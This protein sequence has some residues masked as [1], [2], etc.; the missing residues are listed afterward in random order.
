MVN[1]RSAVV[2]CATALL[3][4]SGIAHAERITLRNGMVLEVQVI[5]ANDTSITMKK[6]DGTT[7]RLART[8]I[9]SIE[10]S[11]AGFL[12]LHR[13][14]DAL[15]KGDLKAARVLLQAALEAGGDPERVNAA[16][17]D[18]SNREHDIEMAVHGVLFRDFDAALKKND[19]GQA[20][21]MLGEIDK[22]LAPDSSLRPD[23]RTR[24]IEFYLRRAQSYRDTVDDTAAINDLNLVREL[25][26]TLM[27]VYL[28]LAN[29]YIK[30][31]K[32]RSE[33]VANFEEGLRLSNGTLPAR[34]EARIH[35]ELAGLYRESGR[36][37]D[38]FH[39]YLDVYRL[40]PRFDNRLEERILRGG[41]DAASLTGETDPA[42]AILLAEE[43]L[44]V[45]ADA[46]LLDR[47]ARYEVVLGRYDDASRTYREVLSVD[48]KYR[49]A[50]YN[51]AQ[52]ALR[53][54]EL[55]EARQLLDQELAF[56]PDNYSA[57]CQLGELSLQRD[58]YDAAF[59][60][61]T[62]AFEVEKQELRAQIGLA[63][64]ARLLKRLSIARKFVEGI[65]AVNSNDLDANLEMGRIL[66]D[67]E[68]YEEA[69][70]Y[71]TIVLDLLDSAGDALPE[72]YIRIKAD[73]LIARGEVRLLTT[74]PSTANADFS[75][76]LKTLPDYPAAFYNIG[77]AYK[78]K[79]GFSKQ[80]GDLK[81]AETNLLRAQELQPKN[82]SYALALGIL[83]H[84]VLAQ[85]D[86]DNKGEYLK[87][88]ATNYTAY[89]TLGGA[90]ASTV[91]QWITECES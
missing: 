17:A 32:T 3:L 5:A 38:S 88:A 2:A 54:L 76:A 59:G 58:D 1:R 91:S 42:A 62:R 24:R 30:N 29:I 72:Q 14:E 84:Q 40:A 37:V 81:E 43:A 35:F 55:F 12:E 71:Y 11:P 16:L 4:L 31:S 8:Q 48:P 82:P 87:K 27:Q 50:N 23:L 26:P 13:A 75:A 57:L 46:D 74:G 51:L 77:L 65:L 20:E 63:R 66:R 44:A 68:N 21:R 9:A 33:A 10:A 60:F 19:Y 47:K 45:K 78:A 61:F 83:Y 36:I 52:L 64:S 6:L 69:S 18:I 39:Q 49:D 34:Q 79:Y 67:E 85:V 70:K 90:D 73:A 53:R 80:I 89:I 7:M 15:R 25:D 41:L 28:D 86:Q 56:Y 22:A